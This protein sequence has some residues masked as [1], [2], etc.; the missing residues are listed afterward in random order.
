MN[1]GIDAGG[2]PPMLS[3]QSTAEVQHWKPNAKSR[4]DQAAT[5][6]DQRQARRTQPMASSM[7]C[8]AYGV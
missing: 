1:A 2:L 6:T 8:T 4:P 7:P 3:G 5:E